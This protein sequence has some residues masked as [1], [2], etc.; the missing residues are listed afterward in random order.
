MRISTLQKTAE[1]LAAGIL[2]G[3]TLMTLM[4]WIER[5]SSQGWLAVFRGSVASQLD[6]HEAAIVWFLN[7]R[8]SSLSQGAE[9][10]REQLERRA[11]ESLR[12]KESH[13]Y[14][15]ASA[16]PTLDQGGTP[17]A[18]YPVPVLSNEYLA[19]EFGVSPQQMQALAMENDSLLKEYGEMKQQIDTTHA[20]INEIARLQTTLQEQLTYQAAQID[21][22]FDE[23]STTVN[24]IQRANTHLTQ[25]SKKRSG[26]VT[27]FLWFMVMATLFVLL[28][29]IISD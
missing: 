25:A 18:G 9:S 3:T 26:S 10:Y 28:L 7:H 27:F 11:K 23:T 19:E 22:L 5:R 6:Q 29:H 12:V 14:A 20:S 4:G 13:K 24:T 1:R 8:F 16:R 2:F 15:M 17:A 21:R